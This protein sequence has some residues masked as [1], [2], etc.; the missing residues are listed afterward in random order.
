MFTAV[1]ERPPQDARIISSRI[2]RMDIACI[3]GMYPQQPCLGNK[4]FNVTLELFNVIL[5]LL[6]P[7]RIYPFLLNVLPIHIMRTLLS[8]A[9]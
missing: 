7:A 6:P 3:L 1:L 9:A 2:I 8:R 4:N 5:E